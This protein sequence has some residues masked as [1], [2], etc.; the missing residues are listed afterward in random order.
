MIEVYAKTSVDSFMTNQLE[1][2]EVEYHVERKIAH[3]LVEHMIKNELVRFSK[4]DEPNE[5]TMMT[6]HTGS[7]VTATH[8]EKKLFN[9][10]KD[11]IEE[12]KLE[13]HFKLFTERKERQR[14]LLQEMTYLNTKI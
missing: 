8:E 14:E 2:K 10:M 9:D 4:E 7:I 5:H 13:E 11:F 1:L 6:T 12:F 3:E